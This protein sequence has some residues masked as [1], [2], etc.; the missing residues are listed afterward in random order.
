MVA[1]A[2]PAK[3]DTIVDPLI[4]QLLESASR[5]IA[6][7]HM[8]A[9]PES[10][11]LCVLITN[12]SFGSRTGSELFV[13]DLALQLRR[14]SHTPI[15]YS[16]RLGRLA[17][18]VRAA[19]IQVVDDL[20]SLSREPDLIH[21]QHHLETM[22]ALVRFPRAPA[23]FACHG[24]LP[25]Q[26]APPLHP[27]ILHYLAVSEAARDRVVSMTGAP[28]KVSLT[29]NFV[30]LEVY[31]PRPP[32]PVR[33]AKALVFSNQASELNYL[34]IVREACALRGINVDV[35]GYASGTS[36]DAPQT[37]LGGYDIVF[38]RG[39]AAIESLAVGAAVV[40]CDLEGLGEMVSTDNLDRMR[41][42]NFGLRELDRAVR[43]DLL[44]AQIDRYD[45][46]SAA[47]V[48]RRIRAGASVEDFVGIVVAR[49]RDVIRQWRAEGERLQSPEAPALHRYLRQVSVM[50]QRLE[51]DV[52]HW[53]RTQAETN[54]QLSGERSVTERTRTD[55]EALQ[56]SAQGLREE[57][58]AARNAIESL[59]A[60]Q[61]GTAAQLQAVQR[62]LEQT[63]EASASAR[64]GIESEQAQQ[65]ARWRESQA[66][67]E[68]SHAFELGEARARTC[69]V[70]EQLER[71]RNTLTWRLRE[72]LLAI[73]PLRRAYL[74]VRS[75]FPGR[76]A[77]DSKTAAS[78]TAVGPGSLL[79]DAEPRLA[80]VVMSLGNPETLIAA[81][82]SLQV[83]DVPVEIVVVNSGGGSPVSALRAAGIEVKVLHRPDRLFPGAVRNLGIA[84]TT[85]P[86]IAFLAADC[87]A[88]P[89]W[90]AARITRHSMGRQAV[91]SAVIPASAGNLWSWVSYLNL[92]AMRMPGVS[93]RHALHYGVSYARGLFE[94]H[95]LFRSDLRSG[96]DSEFNQ[97]LTGIEFDWAPEIR[98]AHAH[99]TTMFGLLRDHYGRGARIAAAWARLS[100]RPSRGRVARGAVTR[101]PGLLRIA[102]NAAQPGERRYVLAAAPLTPLAVA[103]YAFGALTGAASASA[104]PAAG[105]ARPR[106]LA[107]LTFHDEMRYLPDYF[108]NLAPH[109]DGIIALD[110]GSGDGSGEFVESQALVRELI[111]LPTRQPHVWDEPRNRR[112]LVEA[113]LRHGA[114]WLVVLDADERVERDF[115]KRADAQMQRADGEGTL[116]LRLV[117]RE[118]WNHADHF[119]CD[120]IWDRKRPVR[121][122]KA[123]ADH[124]FDERPLHGYWAPLNSLDAESCGDADL[125]IYHLRMLT[126]IERRA[127]QAKY[128]RLDPNRDFQEIGY[129]YLTDTAS[130]QLKKLPPYREYQPM[131]GQQSS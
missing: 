40:C 83:Q 34:G 69:C 111:R 10:N 98:S 62:E 11:A 39:R 56:L 112:L 108:R 128:Q 84:A 96:E 72:R 4:G 20:E 103:A 30:D 70:E 86:W 117:M 50:A 102:W 60:E 66:S 49:Y 106:L 25:W 36:C 91:S 95:G 118:L 109:V 110:D 18:E 7:E 127:R 126:E 32:L 100:G 1:T 105:V 14:R 71:Q 27:R 80:C 88:E 90:A 12:T 68:A 33:A 67:L 120:G 77:N 15:V 130:L 79:D 57:T 116:A 131:H 85:A 75:R 121:M 125:V 46:Q 76:T 129:D 65:R 61:L 97:R 38:A 89:G 19:G 22:A 35:A 124:Q 58:A 51:D 26:E 6:T 114:D 37:I 74:L 44:C 5:S 47:E 31:L 42:N 48:S 104:L 55:L 94:E 23:L 59:K 119:R 115:R 82:H 16:P 107:L 64:A 81:V 54:A 92:F 17:E 13:R 24:F 99:P 45:P 53:Q 113:A 9:S 21:G 3:F 43:V 28:E 101:V 63:L 2:H 41:R 52:H 87:L 78:A 29:L 123:R 93:P 122:F 8:A 73:E